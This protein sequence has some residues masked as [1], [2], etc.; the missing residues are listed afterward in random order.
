MSIQDIGQKLK[1][2]VDSDEIFMILLIILVS[3][4]S[5]GLGRASVEVSHTEMTQNVID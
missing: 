3:V 4:A 2:F 1:G 5:F